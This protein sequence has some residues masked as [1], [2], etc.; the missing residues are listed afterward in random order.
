MPL[1]NQPG[2][3]WEYGIGIDWAGIVLERATGVK[4]DDWIQQNITRPLGLENVTMFPTEHMKTELAFMH[5]RWPG[6]H[7][8]AEERD[9]VYR[10]P[11]LAE[12]EHDKKHI[13]HSGGAGA[14]AKPIEYVQVLAALLNDGESPKTGARILKT[15]TVDAMWE[16]QVPDMPDFARQGIPAAKAEQTNPSPE[17][18]YPHRSRGILTNPRA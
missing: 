17:Y 4:L 6:D 11:L 15:Q 13:L 3:K 12:T 9:H 10:E 5:Q 1:V 14:Y 18:V 2:E 16:N 8:R 7:G